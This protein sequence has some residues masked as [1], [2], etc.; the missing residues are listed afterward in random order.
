MRIQGRTLGSKGTGKGT[1]WGTRRLPRRRR[2]WALFAW[3]NVVTLLAN[4]TYTGVAMAQIVP[5]GQTQ[6]HVVTTGTVTDVTTQTRIG[7]SGVNSFRYFNVDTGSTVNMYVP[8]GARNLVNVITGGQRSF[9]DGTV[10]AFREGRIGG[11]VYFLNPDGLVIGQ[12]G[13]VNVG[14]LTLLT[15]TREF[16]DSFFAGGPSGVAASLAR[17]LDGT[18]PIDSA[19]MISV[20]GNVRAVGDVDIQAGNIGIAG[21]IQTGMVFGE[22]APGVGDALNLGN[23]RFAAESVDESGHIRIVAAG[24][25]QH[26]GALLA[27]GR[28]NVRAGTITITASG[29]ILLDDGSVVSARGIGAGSSAGEIAVFAQD[30]AELGASALLDVRGA[31]T[32][33]GG[34]VE[35]SA[36]DTLRLSGG[37]LFAGSAGG[38]VGQ[39]LTDAAQLEITAD[40][41]TDGA[42]LMLS[43]RDAISVFQG[44]TL[45]TRSVAASEEDHESAAS[46]GDSGSMAMEAPVITIG[47]GAR[48]LAHATGGF[49]AGDITLSARLSHDAQVAQFDF[50]GATALTHITIDGATLRGRNITMAAE[51]KARDR[52]DA[53]AMREFLASHMEALDLEGE[54]GEAIGN[55]KGLNIGAVLAR[56]TSGVAVRNNSRLV[57]DQSVTLQ[58][59][60]LASAIFAPTDI[61]K[62]ALLGVVYGDVRSTAN[63]AI[64]SGATVSAQNL[65]LAAVNDATLELPV[66]AR[67]MESVPVAAAVAVGLAQVESSAVIARGAQLRVSDAISISADNTTS[68]ALT[69]TAEA[70]QGGMLGVAASVLIADTR[71]TA[72]L[73]A[74]VAATGPA[75]GGNLSLIAQDRIASHQ[76][77]AESS[78][79][80]PSG[81]NG[82]GDSGDGGDGG[83]GN[84]DDADG[85]D[86]GTGNGDG[87]SDGDD[88]GDDSGNTPAAGGEAFVAGML[89]SRSGDGERQAQL[90]ER[91]GAEDGASQSGG[92]P[93]IGAAV[94]VVLANHA[95]EAA[96]GDHATV[97]A[98]GDV[99]LIARVL[100]PAQIALATSSVTGGQAANLSGAVVV[101]FIDHAATA[102]VGEG[103]SLGAGR[104]GVRADVL[105]TSDM[106]DYD[107]SGL[108]SVKSTLGDGG[109]IAG[110]FMSGY[111]RSSGGGSGGFGLTGA[112]LYMGLDSRARAYVGEGAAVT[113]LGSPGS[114]QTPL[115]GDGDESIDWRS[116]VDIAA[117][118]TLSGAFGAGN[119][120][121]VGDGDGG[122]AVGGSYVQVNYHVLTEAFVDRH[123]SIDAGAGAGAGDASLTAHTAEHQYLIGHGSGGGKGLGLSGN[124]AFSRTHSHTAARIAQHGAVR[125]SD[126]LLQ[127]SDDLKAFILAGGFNRPGANNLSASVA[128]QELTAHTASRVEGSIQAENLSLFALGSNQIVSDV[129]EMSNS[130]AVGLSLV[131]LETTA[132]LARGSVVTVADTVTVHAG[133]TS[134]FT[135][136]AKATAKDGAAAG[137]AGALLFADTRA[138]ASVETNLI[139]VT[140]VN[141]TALDVITGTAIVALTEVEGQKDPDP[142]QGGGQDPP[143]D[144]PDPDPAP[145]PEPTDGTRAAAERLI[146]DHMSDDTLGDKAPSFDA[147]SGADD[148][149]S[150]AQSTSSGGASGGQGKAEGGLRLPKIGGAVSVSVANHGAEATIGSGV[151][152]GALGDVALLAR[153]AQ[154]Q[155]HNRAETGVVS[156]ASEDE[157]PVSISA[158]VVVGLY[159]NEAIAS[160]GQGSRITADRV[161]VRSDVL[162]TYE[163]EWHK[164]EG[165]NSLIEKIKRRKELQGDLVQG[166]LSGF[167][168]STVKQ[169]DGEYGFAGSVL[170][171]DFVN[172]SHAFVADDAHIQLT[173][174]GTGS[175]STLLPVGDDPEELEWTGGLDLRATTDLNGAFSAGNIDLIL[176]PQGGIGSGGGKV[177][178]GASYAQTNHFNDTQAYL[179]RNVVVDRLG[180]GASPDVSIRA[181]TGERLF[182][183]TPSAGKGATY[184]LSGNFA[185]ATVDSTTHAFIDEGAD[186][187][188]RNLTL[189]ATQDLLSFSVAGAVNIAEGA[190]IGIGIA[191]QRIYTDTQA[192]LRG[193][194]VTA[195]SA[196]IEARTDGIIET[197]S[198]AGAVASAKDEKPVD[199][200]APADPD[201]SKPGNTGLGQAHDQLSGGGGIVESAKSLLEQGKSIYDLISNQDDDANI[202]DVL[203]ALFRADVV[204]PEE[205]DMD[206]FSGDDKEA[207]EEAVRRFGE[208]LADDEDDD[209]S[210]Q[211]F[212]IQ[213]DFAP[214]ADS[215]SG[216]GDS[217]RF[218]LGVSG[219]A[220][221]NVARLHTAAAVEESALTMAPGSP[222]DVAVRALNH[223]DIGAFSGSASLVRAGR[224]SSGSAAIAGAAAVNDLAN[225]THARLTDSQLDQLGRTDVQAMAAGD[226]LAIG[227]GAAVNASANGQKAGSAAGSVSVSMTGNQVVAAVGR[228]L[229]TGRSGAGAPDLGVL[230][231]DRARLGTGGGSLVA[232]GKG[233]FGAAVTY[234]AIKNTSS[235]TI[236]DSHVSRFA[237]IDVRARTAAQIGAGGA[238]IGATTQAGSLTLGG[239]FVISEIHNE[240]NAGIS[241]S[242]IT[243]SGDVQVTARDIARGASEAASWNALLDARGCT[244][245]CDDGHEEI[246]DFTASEVRDFGDLSDPD[247]QEADEF[248]L[249]PRE[250]MPGSSIISVAGVVQAGKGSNVGLSVVWNDI[251]NQFSATV[252]DTYADVTGGVGVSADSYASIMGFAVGAG[253]GQQFSGG[254]SLMNNMI[255]NTTTAEVR[256]RPG[257]TIT[258]GSLQIRATDQSEILAI[259]GQVNVSLKSASAGLSLTSGLTLNETRA[260]LHGVGVDTTGALQ[261]EADNRARILAFSITGAV[262]QG[263]A[264]G[265]AVTLAMVHNSAEAEI[266]GD[267]MD[268]ASALR[269]GT[270]NIS[271]ANTADIASLAGQ[272]SVG[273]KGAAVGGAFGVNLTLNETIARLQ[274]VGADV[275]DR[276][277]IA[278]ANDS[279]IRTISVSG[280]VSGGQAA[281]GG[282]ISASHIQN[283]AVAELLSDRGHSLT[284]N[285]L[286]VDAR[287]ESMIQALAGQ[288]SIGLSGA[289]V[290]ASLLYGGIMNEARATASGFGVTTTGQAA[291]TA[292]SDAELWTVGI[293]VGV[294]SKVGVSGSLGVSLIQ[295]QTL[296][297]VL[298]SVSSPRTWTVGSLRVDAQDT[299]A[300]RAFTGNVTGGGTAAVGGSLVHAHI[301]NTAASAVRDTH[302]QVANALSVQAQNTSDIQAIAVGG[303]VAGKGAVTGSGLS[304]LIHN[305]TRV[306]VATSVGTLAAGSLS[307]GAEDRSG[308]QSFAG[309][310]AG[311][312]VAAVGGALANSMIFNETAA[313]LAGYNIS[314]VGSAQVDAANTSSIETAAITGGFA[315]KAAVQGSFVN[316]I[317]G[318]RTAATAEGA[319]RALQAASLQIGARDESRIAFLSG[320][321]SG[322]GAAAVGAA[323]GHALITNTTA[324]RLS[325]YDVQTVGQTSVEAQNK[326]RLETLTI[327]L[328]A[329]GAAAVSGS[330]SSVE[331][332][333][334]TLAEAMGGSTL[335]A[336][337][338]TV[339]AEDRAAIITSSEEAGG[340]GAAS[341]GGSLANSIIGNRTVARLSGYAMDVGGRT[342]I[343][344]RNQSSIST[345]A[346]SAGGAGA[347]AVQGSVAS[348]HIQNQTEAIVERASAVNTANVLTVWA[349]DQA[350][351]S[352]IAGSG[353]VGGKVGVG[354][355]VAVNRIANTTAATVD[356]SAAG[357]QYRVGS[358]QV[359]AESAAQIGNAAAAAGGGAI[360][361][362]AGSVATNYID[363]ETESRIRGGAVV[364]AE[365]NVGVIAEGHDVLTNLS[366][367]LGIAVKGVGVGASVTVNILGGH[368]RALI[369][370][371]GTQVTG[372]A[373][374][375]TG[376]SVAQGDIADLGLGSLIAGLVDID[377]DHFDSANWRPDLSGQLQRGLV[378][379]V[380]VNAAGT[381]SIVNVVGNA[382]GGMAAGIAGT[383]SVSVVAGSTRAY[384]ADAALNASDVNRA[385]AHQTVSIQATDHAY[386]HDFV[387][388][389][390]AGIA[391]V[392]VGVDTVVFDRTTQA[393][394][395]DSQ[396]RAAQTLAVG[397]RASQGSTSVTVGMSAGGVAVAGTANV[398]I[399]SSR[400]LAHVSGGSIT[401]RDVQVTAEQDT[402]LFAL[403]GG[404]AAGGDAGSG[405]AAVS[406]S[407]GV[408]RAFIDGATVAATRNVRVHAAND[409]YVDIWGASGGLGAFNGLAGT[410]VVTLTN[411]TTEA[412][413]SRSNVGSQAARVGSISVTAL[414]QI[415]VN[416]RGGS[417]GLG[418]VGA[419]VGVAALIV[420]ANGS[421]SAY[422]DDAHLFADRSTGDGSGVTIGA[423][424]QRDLAIEGGSAG[425]GNIAGVAGVVALVLSGTRMQGE[426][427]DELARRADVLGNVNAMTTGD[428]LT[429]G[430]DGDENRNVETSV[431]LT[432]ADLDRANAAGRFDVQ[433]A[434]TH[435]LSADTEAAVRGASVIDAVGDVTV[436]AEERTRVR[437]TTVNAAIGG[438]LGVGG[439][440]GVVLL[441]SS[442]DAIVSGSSQLQSRVGSIAV[443]SSIGALQPGSTGVVMDIYQGSGGFVGLG[444]AI[445]VVD[446]TN[447]ART[448]IGRGAQL[449]ADAPTGSITLAARD[450]LGAQAAAHGLSVGAVSAGAVVATV[451]K[452]G[453]TQVL[454]G[455]QAAAGPATSLHAG[456]D[457]IVLAERE[458]DVSATT[459]AAAGGVL[460]AGTGSV[461]VARDT[462]GVAVD[463]GHQVFADAGGTLDAQARALPG[464]HTYAFGVSVAGVVSVGV[465]LAD[466]RAQVDVRATYG[467]GGLIRAEH[468]TLGAYVATGGSGWTATSDAEASSGGLV[469]VQATSSDA[470]SRATTLTR[471]DS[472]AVVSGDIRVVADT[473]T[474]Q[475]ALVRGIVAGVAAV[476]GNS[477]EAGAA[478]E[479]LVYIGDVRFHAGTSANNLDIMARSITVQAYAHDENVAGA[480]AG[481]GGVV[482][483]SAAAATARHRST[484]RTQIGSESGSGVRFIAGKLDIGALHE[485]RYDVGADSVQAAVAGMSGALAEKYVT[486]HVNTHIG[487]NSRLLTF[488]ADV[489]A[490]SDVLQRGGRVD[491]GAGGVINAAAAFSAAQI[492]QRSFVDIGS[493]VKMT[494]FDI[495]FREIPVGA[496][497]PDVEAP[498]DVIPYDPF[499]PNALPGNLRLRA[500][501]SL[502]TFDEAILQTGGV[503]QLP[504]ARAR[505]VADLATGVH[506]GDDAFLFSTGHLHVNAFAWGSARTRTLASTAGLAG[507]AIGR[508][509]SLLTSDH[510]V[511]VGQNVH[512]IAHRDVALTAGQSA[513]GFLPATVLAQANSRV[514]N[515]TA[516]PARTTPYANAEVRHFANVAIGSGSHVTAVLDVTIAAADDTARAMGDGIGV[517]TYTEL[518]LASEIKDGH[519]S[520]TVGST[521][522]ID[523][524]VTAGIWHRQELTISNDGSSF[525]LGPTTVDMGVEL[526][527]FNPLEEL[528]EQIEALQALLDQGGLTPEE[529]N[530]IEA[531]IVVLDTLRSSETAGSKPSAIVGDIYAAGGNVRLHGRSIGGSGSITALGGPTIEIHNPSHRYLVLDSLRIPERD[532]GGA[533]MFTGVATR[534]DVSGGLAARLHEVDRDRQARIVV[535]NTQVASKGPGIYLTGPITNLTG[536]VRVF[537]RSGNVGQ[538][539]EVRA[540]SIEI[541]TPNGT[542]I[543]N[544][545]GQHWWAAG[546]PIGQWRLW[547]SLPTDAETAAAIALSYSLGRTFEGLPLSQLLFNLY[548]RDPLGRMYPDG[549][550]R[551]ADAGG[552]TWVFTNLPNCWGSFSD[553]QKNAATPA[554]Y[555]GSQSSYITLFGNADASKG[556][557]FFMRMAPLYA[558]TRSASYAQAA[559]S[560][561]TEGVLVGGSIAINARYIDIN[562]VISSGVPGDRSVHILDTAD[563]WAQSIR[564]AW[565][566]NPASVGDEVALPAVYY[567]DRVGERDAA[568]GRLRISY[569]PATDEFVLDPINASGGGYVY[570]NGHIMSTNQL[571]NIK[572]LSGFGQVDIA[573]DS[574]RHLVVSDIHTGDRAVSEVM[575]VDTARN[576]TSWY[577]HEIGHGVTHYEAGGLRTERA[578]DLVPR[579]YTSG[580][581]MTYNPLRNQRYEWTREA[582][583]RRSFSFPGSSFYDPAQIGNWV[584]V[585]QGDERWHTTS[586][587]LLNQDPSAPDLLQT[588]SGSIGYHQLNVAFVDG[589]K[590]VPDGTWTY[591]VI[592]SARLAV[593]TSVRADNPFLITFDGHDE[594][595]VAIDSQAG[596]TLAGTIH[597]TRGDTHLRAVGQGQGI[598]QTAQA[599][600]RSRS[601]LAVA[602]AGIGSADQ[603]LRLDLGGGSLEATTRTGDIAIDV[604]A[605]GV[606]VDGITAGQD[607]ADGADVRL[608]AAHTIGM[609]AGAIRGAEI[610][611][612]SAQGSVGDRNGALVL[613]A[614]GTVSVTASGDI[615]LVQ[616]GGDLHLVRA[617][618][619]AGDVSIDVQEGRLI[620]A[621]TSWDIDE[622]RVQELADIW[623]EWLRDDANLSRTVERTVT[624]FERRIERAYEEY[625]RL[626]EYGEV[627]PDGSYVLSG[628]AVDVYREWAQA[629]ADSEAGQPAPRVSD[630]DVIAFAGALYNEQVALF[631]DVY[632]GAWRGLPEFAAYSEAYAYTVTQEQFDALTYGANWTRSQLE[633]RVNENA[634]LPV[635][636]TQIINQELNVRGN[637][638]TLSAAH[639]QAGGIGSEDAP[640][641]IDLSSV[642]PDGEIVL[643]PEQKA[644]LAAAALP[645]DVVIVYD[646]DDEPVRIELRQTRSIYLGAS[647]N[648]SLLS[649]GDAFVRVDGNLNLRSALVGRDLTLAANDSILN[650]AAPGTAAIVGHG[651]LVLEAGR[652]SIGTAEAPI[653]FELHGGYVSTARANDSL[654]VASV[655]TTDLRFGG[656]YAG[657]VVR[658]TAA[659]GSIIGGVDGSSGVRIDAGTLSLQAAGD[660]RGMQADSELLIRIG[661]LGKLSGTVGGRALLAAPEQALVVERLTTGSRLALRAASVRF[662]SQVSAGA[663]TMEIV[664]T[665][666]LGEP[667]TVVLAPEASLH[668]GNGPL[669][670]RADSLEMQAGPSG[671]I[672]TLR[673]DGGHDVVIETGAGMKLGVIETL[674]NVILRAG[675]AL[676]D[677]ASQGSITQ[678][679]GGRITGAASLTT[680]S[681]GAQALTGANT[682]ASWEARNQGTG[683]IAFANAAPTLTIWSIETGAAVEI[684]QEGALDVEGDILSAH[685][686]IALTAEGDMLIAADVRAEQGG[687]AL[688]GAGDVHIMEAGTVF[689]GGS[690]VSIAAADTLTIEGS[691][692][693]APSGVHLTAVNGIHVVPTGYVGSGA[694]GLDLRTMGNIVLAGVLASPEVVTLAAGG[695]I[696]QPGTGRVEGARSLE[697]TSD[698]GQTLMGENTVRRFSAT[699]LATGHVLFHNSAAMLTLGAIDQRGGDVT[700]VQTGHLWV[701]EALSTRVGTIRLEALARAPGSE[702]DLQ[703]LQTGSLHAGRLG[704]VELSAAAEL[705]V[706]G[707]VQSDRGAIRL[708]AG[709]G[710]TVS[711]AGAVATAGDI[712]L[713]AADTVT[714]S[715]DVLSL[716]GGIDIDAGQSIDLAARLAAPGR[717]TLLAGAQIVQRS[718]GRIVGATELYAESTTGQQLTGANAVSSFRAVNT[719][720]GDIA[721]VNTADMLALAG[722]EQHAGGVFVEQAGHL[723]VGGGIVSVSGPIELSAAWGALRI[724]A[725]VE[726]A[727]H[728][729]LSLTAHGD[730][731]ADAV[732]RSEHGGVDLASAAGRIVLNDDVQSVD[733][734]VT[735]EAATAIAISGAIATMAEVH[736]T[737]GGSVL[738]AGSGRI[739]GASM[740]TTRSHGGQT[741]LGSNTVAAF[742]AANTGSG[743]VRFANTAAQLEILGVSHSGQVAGSPDGGTAIAVTNVGDVAI[744]GPVTAIAGGV[745]LSSGAGDLTIRTGAE[746]ASSDRVALE[747]EH[748]LRIEEK[749]VVASSQG[750]VDLVA[751]TY[752]A[753]HGDVRANAGRIDVGAGSDISLF[754]RLHAARDVVL[755]SGGN[756]LLAGVIQTPA[757]VV[758]QAGGSLVQSDEG[759]IV[760]A[761]LLSAQSDSW[762]I[763]T[764]Q[765][766]IQQFQGSSTGT[767]GIYLRNASRALEVVQVRHVNGLIEIEQGGDLVVRGNV[768]T[769][770]GRVVL[771]AS[772]S[773]HIR[774]EVATSEAGGIA[775]QS[776]GDLVLTGSIHND[777][778]EI[779]LQAAA[780]MELGGPVESGSGN[781]RLQAGT[782]VGLADIVTTS[783]DIDVVAQE[784][785]LRRPR[786]DGVV[787]AGRDITLG[788]IAGDIGA[789]DL[790]MTARAA[791]TLNA[792][793]FGD[794]WLSIDGNLA[795]DSLTSVAGGIDLWVP[796]GW[797]R[798]GRIEAPNGPVTLRSQGDLVLRELTAGTLRAILS[799]IGA[800]LT[801]G[802]A[803]IKDAVDL[804]AS[805]VRVDH[806]EHVGDEPLRAAVVGPTGMADSVSM[807]GRSG[808]GVVFDLLEAD[809]A[810]ITFI[811]DDL[812]FLDTLVGSTAYLH[813]AHH[814]VIADNVER[815]LLDAHLQVHPR[816]DRFHVIFA[817][818]RRVLS[819]ALD[820]NYDDDYII[821]EFDTENSFVRT[822]FKLPHVVVA[823]PADPLSVVRMPVAGT[824]GGA[825][826]DTEEEEPPL[827]E[828]MGVPLNLEASGAP[829][830]NATET[831]QQAQAPA[832]ASGKD[833]AAADH[834]A[835]STE[836]GLKAYSGER[837]DEHV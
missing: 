693:S 104:L 740:L 627:S 183:I 834:G 208:D 378:R 443:E 22:T 638:V 657:N 80:T 227:I 741:L 50:P 492:E 54:F 170:Y 815:K 833:V 441:G 563:S 448:L 433:A 375:G 476:G 173:G 220:S 524:T 368:I 420:S 666:H 810:D 549:G 111:A 411:N 234:S 746:V 510:R 745:V 424:S 542:Y 551:R 194:D 395:D 531:Q 486:S 233:G 110:D 320:E 165:I 780:G 795:S 565:S 612:T 423:L 791:G 772:G 720:L 154:G 835:G 662:E 763:L 124:F 172:R 506:I 516:V 128:L 483:G 413:I 501:N 543:A 393:Y 752:I 90:D 102:Y 489:F 650:R 727:G 696:T 813:N 243:N 449:V 101:G 221:I 27:D 357:T 169:D 159:E 575:I 545:P 38:Q 407:Q 817:A 309:N 136:T 73:D 767:G 107:W 607:L 776:G 371:A 828:W 569:R 659:G 803:V 739:V 355:T 517:N 99:S 785:I 416:N 749:S 581:V 248:E 460:A 258:A 479:A 419:G 163:M 436:R 189:T 518:G 380:A 119:Q 830:E 429:A 535:N 526:G 731:V 276:A 242:T 583:M 820:V 310:L 201:P 427:E 825:G 43:A 232:G 304:T 300:I 79:A 481:S 391:G 374:S 759:G 145:E 710:L 599:L 622:E 146:Q 643:T 743:S 636:D 809:W 716:M 430:G 812:H 350:S 597:N 209:V 203:L 63:V 421:T 515:Y 463:L 62:S 708:A 403:A 28:D 180:A 94:S 577:V 439:A 116:A 586:R 601:L 786:M 704:R 336:G 61:E 241:G 152:I 301:M 214:L 598:A 682:V 228:S 466:A 677:G 299:S 644:A 174:S 319:G 548:L 191:V 547:E 701:A 823:G 251:S 347:A 70:S 695:S 414:D 777:S 495:A 97:N 293:S 297:E 642:S 364:I 631:D 554:D 334:E 327:S 561:G 139:G 135:I 635:S 562:G 490:V 680:L 131:D 434:L 376:L 294:G 687:V 262:S 788:A 200:S 404:V 237:A 46:V 20:R 207:A 691:V 453:Q 747:A 387:G 678:I 805:R 317:I 51:S 254:G 307:V 689:G 366:G 171:M 503:I 800:S 386:N 534:A 606:R 127:S 539:A 379:G 160:I 74:D 315:G 345:I 114:W 664:A 285:S 508:A 118:T 68:L 330:L 2:W 573:N 784:S 161:G 653:T 497:G 760:G 440:V 473:Q 331:I 782:S 40:Q 576:V 781:I 3:L 306:D 615:H 213:G 120:S 557:H 352:T 98:L 280:S 91:S 616:S 649:G 231:F 756:T 88:D 474:R 478:N 182:V 16:T 513:D 477:A 322:A 556:S 733:G 669:H 709:R 630:A 151:Q 437:V 10:N 742:Q 698:R 587:V 578:A 684:A 48:L 605:G 487:R 769:A 454:I 109:D 250:Q 564:S 53:E 703:V 462:G 143:G 55:L 592:T 705:L 142:G 140:H 325:G 676:A 690:A 348:A 773:A 95:A 89:A 186:V 367:T 737:S 639:A 176:D 507:G 166:Y 363:N 633:L 57:A 392:G 594:G 553:C 738:Q 263:P 198:I 502:V 158:A 681:R 628:G 292:H 65:R 401:A 381:H 29:D 499:A 82:D 432:A 222:G 527:T 667:G 312:G 179:G 8:T 21:T 540:Q 156:H 49:A 318:N 190:G 162:R 323:I 754:G 426:A 77:K 438:Y 295:N 12:Q 274:N 574:Q 269:A 344:A 458:G 758:L 126:V 645:G 674:G 600:T 372:L 455:D 365:D 343:V 133:N 370:G 496:L 665:G 30:S 253:V 67:D 177:N 706:A 467:R 672:A 702:G 428:R 480:L 106:G 87:G 308:I 444:A 761:A 550:K 511:R 771:T 821:N 651:N 9:V 187:T 115:P 724:Q 802:E 290:G 24:N 529:R 399:F 468:F 272:V 270:M 390:A 629:A 44:V 470:V 719:G 359:R 744:T 289:G 39:I 168:N 36:G 215:G 394:L 137:V 362:V 123:A 585:D 100:D 500:Y 409:T 255:R 717:V 226:Q 313:R 245:N 192:L 18:V 314:V 521:V 130:A 85:D 32:D 624:P 793:A 266:D 452:G 646:E 361:G 637:H 149:E 17:V 729:G 675:R 397:A 148:D 589:S 504:E 450:G 493:G 125:A 249:A 296:A 488:D 211:G 648:V 536:L 484:A 75:L 284:A 491:A 247:G 388:T 305:S 338:L 259:A 240:T 144:E 723:L 804:I 485:A 265:G 538:F 435:G 514:F 164:W 608:W 546:D 261:V 78:A 402:T 1:R 668:A 588:R 302:L 533:V 193:S 831:E 590:R 792:A 422:V 19:G 341:V 686:D 287:D 236:S 69:S 178:V 570:L 451:L 332:F 837:R 117:A 799:D 663:G 147:D 329:A 342:D 770:R 377:P 654:H 202:T 260:A 112:V 714:L 559:M 779:A 525:T 655:G 286:A 482:A 459:Y 72:R 762:Q 256:L 113:T 45:S 275:Q 316:A 273:F 398:G 456:G 614:R 558:L 11:N 613:E 826:P 206:Q 229:L 56:A 23:T 555:Y 711:Q 715:G 132:S 351:I 775:I 625:W 728:G 303:G 822:S 369:E 271:A 656:I 472:D 268:P 794:I 603:P 806:L 76:V 282:S 584:W 619:A 406:V 333:N 64:A 457:L 108:G 735:L 750:G 447:R 537:N 604:V 797:M 623:D 519:S 593:T 60:S 471:M 757:N 532:T 688:G 138:N 541:E 175:W 640:L 288:A 252:V 360:A 670:V 35:L 199:P 400:A 134:S 778:G 617:H 596:M 122:I 818:D 197:I 195:S 572:V 829:A 494:V 768:Q 105:R 811:T 59:S 836:A 819:N 796:N 721:L 405:T 328:G 647:G 595:R 346:A 734:N 634:L 7:N 408:S 661:S 103:A 566:A 755:T 311:A 530:E 244:S 816:N 824:P 219:S 37:Q 6:T 264:I 626:L 700:V 736:L 610:T 611:L 216:T 283:Q 523:G 520:E 86:N 47:E 204:K 753:I 373:R 396:A 461:A 93:E 14:A 141:V 725:L 789:A 26:S 707:D 34:V 692:E 281:V 58:V 620:N 774:A 31:A 685:G 713:V 712:A 621:A 808:V 814:R 660:V 96:I 339:K 632:S 218:G 321:A 412:Y 764:G 358:M 567:S 224:D 694:S 383:T 442:A 582:R 326:A 225:T 697:A 415:A 42:D 66:N 4:S 827:F 787:L 83:T 41:F 528:T 15:P 431:G 730:V 184:G 267:A 417:A 602:D 801:V 418:I 230:A 751:G 552:Y 205:L 609:G 92:L 732:I 239:S 469:G 185:L 658:L 150:G 618:A 446:T 223:T 212:A 354:A 246:F 832:K 382:A 522:A 498:N 121:A 766:Q 384:V 385:S 683:D 298:S 798:V 718:A 765:N 157:L 81:D 279:T 33:P 188:A 410:A 475:Q 445:A 335:R 699:N 671:T 235:S 129:S 257:N 337:A 278:A 356:G 153:V 790:R 277:Q 560:G 783:G 464:V 505:V 71:A 568:G 591:R 324:S 13:T 210:G 25:V 544:L 722:I 512:L 571:G 84:G 465:S 238:M 52:W 748:A 291:V 340:A 389:M 349:D 217:P 807:Y 652:G 196:S 580:N 509:E 353:G 673:A 167:A 5:D 579:S 155:V 726:T 181:A 679:A 641:I 425:V